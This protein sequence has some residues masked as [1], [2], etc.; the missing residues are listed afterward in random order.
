M[1]HLGRADASKL[2]RYLEADVDG[3]GVLSNNELR[4]AEE[5][6]DQFARLKTLRKIKEA[7]VYRRNKKRD[8]MSLF[9]FSVFSALPHPVRADPGGERVRHRL[10]HAKLRRAPEREHRRGPARLLQQGQHLLVDEGDARSHMGRPKVR[11]RRM[12]GRRSTRALASLGCTADCGPY[13]LE[14]LSTLHI[15]IQPSYKVDET[16][17]DV[18]PRRQVPF[19]SRLEPLHQATGKGRQDWGCRRIVLVRRGAKVQG[20]GWQ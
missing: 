13:P 10:D 9:L 18:P 5:G 1:T 4:L 11:R 15:D 12:F 3:D 7:Y 14:F 20:Q 16:D 2:E 19:R 17:A 6:E 8:Y